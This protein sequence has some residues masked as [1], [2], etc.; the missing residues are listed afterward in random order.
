M[1]W[2]AALICTCCG[3][4]LL[5]GEDGGECSSDITSS[6]KMA[7]VLYVVLDGRVAYK[8]M[9]ALERAASAAR[10]MKM[11]RAADDLEKMLSW[12]RAHPD[13]VWRAGP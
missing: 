8:T 1:S 9:R 11:P 10:V 7:G 2:S 3:R 13:G 5:L 6:T 4:A 12:A